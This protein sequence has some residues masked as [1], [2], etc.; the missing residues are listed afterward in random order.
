MK[1]YRKSLGETGQKALCAAI[2]F[3]SHSSF[4]VAFFSDMR[5]VKDLSDENRTI[6]LSHGKSRYVR[7]RL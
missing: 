4:L 6:S 1:T 5:P 2:E 3:L 7:M